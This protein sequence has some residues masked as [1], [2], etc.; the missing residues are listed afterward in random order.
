MQWISLLRRGRS[1]TDW[2]W[3]GIGPEEGNLD[4]VTLTTLITVLAQHTR[5]AADCWFCLWDGYGWL[6]DSSGASTDASPVNTAALVKKKQLPVRLP[7]RS[8]LLGR[9]PL[10]SALG[11]GWQHDP[12]WFTPQSPNIFW[13][14]DRAWCVA[15][16]IDFDST[17]VAGSQ[18]LIN[19]LRQTDGLE[20]WPI[21]P[22]ASLQID[23]D[24]VN[25]SRPPR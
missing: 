20:T 9:G 22:D 18:Q 12:D 25:T 4:P 3:H 14:A 1:A 23:A 2:S 13:P 16:E 15:T 8:Y 19:Q 5:T 11:V 24:R 17:L 21:Q 7:G 10:S 6:Y